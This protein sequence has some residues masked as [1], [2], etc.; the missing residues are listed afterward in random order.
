[1][2]II[3]CLILAIAIIALFF[4]IY[5][6]I[7]LFKTKVP[8]VKTPKKSIP[9]I[10]D[11]LPGEGSLTITDL[12]CG[13]ADVLFAL[14]KSLPR[15]KLIGYE[16]SPTAY[17]RARF[18]KWL[19]KSKVKLYYQDF[20]KADLS[21]IDVVFCFLITA[22]MPKLEK[23][24]QRELK[25]GALVISYGF[26]FPNWRPVKSLPNPDPKSRSRIHIYKR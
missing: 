6:M 7:V 21:Q 20:Y 4:A 5:V 14:E 13:D 15:A 24:L 17:I 1:M 22:V 19:K 16:L 25:S 23:K 11:N 26:T 8:F 18:K 2:I 12:G 9:L 10:I 3:L